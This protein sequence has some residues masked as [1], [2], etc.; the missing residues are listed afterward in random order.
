MGC[1]SSPAAQLFRSPRSSPHA[2]PP[3]LAERVRHA[4]CQYGRTVGVLPYPAKVN[5]SQGNTIV[6]ALD[7]VI[8]RAEPRGW[9]LSPSRAADFMTCPLL[10]RFRVIDRLP[11]APSAVAA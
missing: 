9:S 5:Q 6:D 3:F 1:A 11:A 10:Y 7:G 2:R 4:G 8:E